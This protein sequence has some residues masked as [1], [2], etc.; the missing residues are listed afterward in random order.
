[1]VGRREAFVWGTAVVVRPLGLCACCV[2]W[3]NDWPHYGHGAGV[4]IGG[5]LLVPGWVVRFRRPAGEQR[6]GG[7]V[8]EGKGG[9]VGLVVAWVVLPQVEG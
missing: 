5:L 2:G 8:G 6:M 1:M 3:R 7:P 4:A 9:Q